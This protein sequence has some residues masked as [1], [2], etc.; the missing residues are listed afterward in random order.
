MKEEKLV[1]ISRHTDSTENFCF[2]LSTALTTQNISHW[3]ATRDV[4]ALE[5]YA[6]PINENIKKSSLFVLLLNEEAKHS[7]HVKREVEL[8]DKNDIPI[9]IVRMDHSA[10]VSWTEYYNSTSQW[11]DLADKNN[12]VAAQELTQIIALIL[13]QG[14]IDWKTYNQND[15]DETLL[16]SYEDDGERRRLN[17]QR[18]FIYEFAKDFYDNFISQLEQGNFLDVGCST[19][20]QAMLFCNGRKE[21][22]NFIGID[23]EEKALHVASELYPEG[24]FY[25]CQFENDDFNEILCSIEQDLGIDGF[26]IINISMVLLHL[27][28][29]LTFLDIVSDHLSENGRIIILDIDDGY[30]FAYPDEKGIFERAVSICSKSKYSGSRNSGRQV[31]KLLSEIDMDHIQL[32]KTGISTVGMNRKRREE[33]FDIYFWFILDDL[34]KMH[35][36]EPNNTMISENL[37]WMEEKYKE[38]KLVFKN[39]NFYF[40][41]GFMLFSATNE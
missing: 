10:D 8:A 1:F 31:C 9:M 23:R 20:E 34:R 39:K 19:G 13:E 11:V 29:P 28:D 24:H 18:T 21:I 32:H 36:E 41:L 33:F 7:K 22:K 14:K 6:E 16:N 37:D 2:E 27:K 5:F 26:D 15:R 38:M 30:N 40:N 25:K 35:Q 12:V 3:Y 4:M 17:L